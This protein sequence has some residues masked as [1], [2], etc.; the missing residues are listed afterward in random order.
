MVHVPI[1]KTKSITIRHFMSM[2]YN[3]WMSGGLKFEK[4]H[5]RI[6][7][8]RGGRL[9]DLILAEPVAR[10][11]TQG[12]RACGA[13]A[14]WPPMRDQLE[15]TCR[16]SGQTLLSLRNSGGGL[17]AGSCSLERPC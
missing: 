4:V 16:L 6:S 13:P 5:L 11:L 1:R 9:F 14:E 10:A 2:Y 3:I 8:R 7:A 12:V 17:T 15:L